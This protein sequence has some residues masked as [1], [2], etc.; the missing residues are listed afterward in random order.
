M[1]QFEY[2]FIN[3]HAGK[4]PFYRGRN[5]LN[6]ALI[7]DEKEIG[8]TCHYINEGIDKGDIILQKSFPI[9][10]LDDYSTLLEKAI[11]LCPKVLS[12]SIELIVNNRVKAIKQPAQ[13]TYFVQRK[14]GD[15]FIDWNWNSRRIFN[16]VRAITTPGPCAQTWILINSKYYKVEIKKVSLIHDAIDYICE[17]GAIIGL[18]N[19]KPIVKTENSSILIE[20]YSIISNKKN[21]MRIGDRLGINLNLLISG[22]VSLEED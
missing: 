17:N 13:G 12:Q 20:E 7:N 6:W 8:V 22:K 16:F 5:I 9:T 15:E 10:D 2:G 4:L 11:D 1:D 14:E 18:E 3:C 19:G 21:K